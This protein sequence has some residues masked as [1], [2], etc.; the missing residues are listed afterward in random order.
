MEPEQDEASGGLVQ[1]LNIVVPE[2]RLLA[3]R[4]RCPYLVRLEVAD[5][6]LEGSDARLYAS[7]APRVGIT[8]EEALCTRA[9]SCATADSNELSYEHCKLPIELVPVTRDTE[10][11][12]PSLTLAS[13]GNSSTAAGDFPRGGWQMEADETHYMHSSPYDAVRENEYEQL[14]QHMQDG[15]V[16][17]APPQCDIER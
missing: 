5:T 12:S 8:V 15:Q 2:S 4:E 3:S 16:H 7:G 14:H 9:S 11:K 10:I 6:G 1:V 13:D 17:S